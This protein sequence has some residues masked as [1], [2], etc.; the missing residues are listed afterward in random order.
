MSA[1]WLK[2]RKFGPRSYQLCVSLQAL[3]FFYKA[4]RT[5]A[6]AWCLS[7]KKFYRTNLP[8]Q[9]ESEGSMRSS[10]TSTMCKLWGR[11]WRSS[12]TDSELAITSGRLAHL[13]ITGC[14]MSTL[15][16][17]VPLCKRKY[18]PWSIDSNIDFYVLSYIFW[19]PFESWWWSSFPSCRE[20][21]YMI[22]KMEDYHLSAM[23]M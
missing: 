15:D 22:W 17:R 7:E 14:A 18:S 6:A 10:M 2:T 5:S 21:V 19:C 16:A 20:V 4:L 12:W 8:V 9:R 3:K 13:V 23:V 1:E 11:R